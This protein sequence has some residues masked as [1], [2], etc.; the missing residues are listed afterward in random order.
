MV[1]TKFP[2]GR[3][4]ITPAARDA[5]GGESMTGHHLL[6]RHARGDWGDVCEF[7]RRANDEALRE[8]LRLFSVYT[9]T[10]DLVIWI[11]TEA[12]RS[13]TTILLPSDY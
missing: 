9:I 1:P 8:G 6:A 5:L 11:I 4:V 12:D 13:V 7:D 2:F 10:P 3:I